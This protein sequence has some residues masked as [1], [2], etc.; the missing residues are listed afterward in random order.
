MKTLASNSCKPSLN[1]V[2]IVR[3]THGGN[4]KNSRDGKSL[5]IT[6]LW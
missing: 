2:T 4:K 3:L 1:K 6:T 5:T